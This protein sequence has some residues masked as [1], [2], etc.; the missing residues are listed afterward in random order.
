M[1][2]FTFTD[3]TGTRCQDFVTCG[4][5]G[6]TDDDVSQNRCPQD[7][8]MLGEITRPACRETDAC[9]CVAC[10]WRKFGTPGWMSKRN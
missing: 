6:F 1:T 2:A 7:G 10:M 9:L 4:T 5:C 3:S 8:A